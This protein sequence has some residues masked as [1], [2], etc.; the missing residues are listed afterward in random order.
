MATLILSA[1][2]VETTLQ[3][4]ISSKIEYGRLQIEAEVN[5]LVK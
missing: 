5:G 2:Q 1:N 3:M 4:R